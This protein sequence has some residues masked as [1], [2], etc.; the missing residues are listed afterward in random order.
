MSRSTAAP[1]A[2]GVSGTDA[3]PETSTPWIDPSMETSPSPYPGAGF[4][5][6]PP[7]PFAP[8]TPRVGP[9]PKPRTPAAPGGSS[10]D[11]SVMKA[12]EE[13]NE[14]S[15]TWTSASERVTSLTG[16]SP[17]A[18]SCAGPSSTSSCVSSSS[19]AVVS[20]PPSICAAM[21]ASASASSS[22]IIG[23]VSTPLAS[24]SSRS[25]SVLRSSCPRHT[26]RSSICS[27]PSAVAA[28]WPSRYPSACPAR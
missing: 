17:P 20:P 14:V 1:P 24:R 22:A 12:T 13:A 3:I 15:S 8:P 6:N 26:S 2:V 27:S 11:A 23:A 19:A 4:V 25:R 9:K 7:L 10:A 16:G 28:A 5:V 18:S 21:F